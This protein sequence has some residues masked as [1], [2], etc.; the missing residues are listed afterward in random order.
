MRLGYA[1]LVTAL[2]ITPRPKV[3]AAGQVLSP[4]QIKKTNSPRNLTFVSAA[5]IAL[6]ILSARAEAGCGPTCQS[7]CRIAVANGVYFSFEVCVAKW[8]KINAKGS[9]YAKQREAEEHKRWQ[10][11]QR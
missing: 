5:A 6:M 3:V 4:V 11:K 7:K 2:A 9:V 1:C 10:E 8:S